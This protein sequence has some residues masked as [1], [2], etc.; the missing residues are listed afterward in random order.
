MVLLL[1]LRL[2]NPETETAKNISMASKNEA[3]TGD[4]S[5]NNEDNLDSKLTLPRYAAPNGIS[6][7]LPPILDVQNALG[8][9]IEHITA[10][11][12]S[13]PQPPILIALNALGDSVKSRTA[14]K[15]ASAPI[16]G[17]TDTDV[18]LAAA[19]DMSQVDINASVKTELAEEDADAPGMQ[20]ADDNSELMNADVENLNNDGNVADPDRTRT[21]TLIVP[22]AYLVEKER[23]ER[24]SW[25]LRFSTYDAELIQ[26]WYKQKR[27]L[28]PAPIMIIAIITMGVF[29]GNKGGGPS[30]NACKPKSNTCGPDILCPG[31]TCCSDDGE[32]GV[33]AL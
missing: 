9:S 11:P 29:L 8:D 25:F 32:C 7:P 18:S 4:C 28:I 1:R 16:N 3:S 14:R 17:A 10:D 23:E 12:I 5:Q 26:P 15:L 30:E 6:P 13:P 21:G 19:L 31:G 24:L 27:F 2:S 20:Q 22:E 33:S